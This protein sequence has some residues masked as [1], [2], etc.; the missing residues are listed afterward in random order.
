MRGR[1]GTLRD[2][3]SRVASEQDLWTQPEPDDQYAEVVSASARTRS[4]YS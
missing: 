1:S 3:P 2:A 4:R